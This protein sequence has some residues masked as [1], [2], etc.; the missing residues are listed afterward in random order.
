MGHPGA[1]DE[2]P[3]RDLAPGSLARR[4]EPRQDASRQGEVIMMKWLYFSTD[5]DVALDDQSEQ[6]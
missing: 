2:I 5:W 1:S 4:R 3:N 6:A